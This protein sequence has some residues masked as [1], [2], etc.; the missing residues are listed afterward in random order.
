MKQYKIILRKIEIRILFTIDG[1]VSEDQ[2]DFDATTI[3]STMP[4]MITVSTKY[5]ETTMLDKDE[6]TTIVETGESC[7]WIFLSHQI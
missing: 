6:E 7:L 2:E 5:D 3:N 1:I 4:E